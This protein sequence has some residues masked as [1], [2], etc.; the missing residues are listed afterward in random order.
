MT[1]GATNRPW[2]LDAAVLSRFERRIL[3]NLPNAEAR[4]DIFRIHLEDKG[5][6]VDHRSLSYERLAAQTERLTGR[7]IARLCKEV[8]ASMLG[9]MNPEIPN[10][11]DAGLARIQEYEIKIRALKQGDFNDSVEHLVADTSEADEHQ[12]A[13]WGKAVN[14]GKRA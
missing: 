7:E 3:I 10:L 4:A 8:T 11:V 14:E 5:I 6:P 12:Y 2:D 1:V 13:D 9:E